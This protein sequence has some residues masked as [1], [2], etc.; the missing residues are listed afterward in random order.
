MF[1]NITLEVRFSAFQFNINSLNH[2]QFSTILTALLQWR[3][4]DR[5]LLYL[6]NV[7]Q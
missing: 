2:A 4:Q 1:I 6:F 3:A 7:L 5:P